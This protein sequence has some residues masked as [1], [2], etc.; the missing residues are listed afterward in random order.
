[1]QADRQKDIQCLSCL[2]VTLSVS[3]LSLLSR[4]ATLSSSIAQSLSLCLLSLCVSL[5]LSDNNLTPSGCRFSTVI[6][7]VKAP[8]SELV[9]VMI[10]SSELRTRPSHDSKTTY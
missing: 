2:S 8:N 10:P 6:P 1:M 3:N 9:R 4:C 7:E 5:S